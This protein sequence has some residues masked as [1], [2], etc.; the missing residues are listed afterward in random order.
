M[1]KKL[2]TLNEQGQA[3]LKTLVDPF[4]EFYI[5]AVMDLEEAIENEDMP[6]YGETVFGSEH[7]DEIKGEWK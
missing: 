6:I 4:S 3:L 1:A 7:F 5:D 2:Y